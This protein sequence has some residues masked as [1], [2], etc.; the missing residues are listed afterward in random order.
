M[1]TFADVLSLGEEHLEPKPSR[2]KMLM[3]EQ[4]IGD[5]ESVVY[6]IIGALNHNN[7][8]I[9]EDLLARVRK[10]Y[11]WSD[12]LVELIDTITAG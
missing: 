8:A 6:G 5:E 12:T 7:V 4:S 10:E 11:S 2:D 9:S 3:F 1:S